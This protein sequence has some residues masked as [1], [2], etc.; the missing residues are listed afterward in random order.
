M[1]TPK[2]SII[3]PVY[4]LEDYIENCVRSLS[5]QV[6]Q[7]IEIII[8]DDGSS[9]NSLSIIK[10]LAATDSRIIYKTQPNGGAAKARNTG[11]DLSTGDYIAF[12]DGDDMLSTNAISDNIGYFVD[13]EIDWVAFSIRRV[14]ADGEYI[15]AKGIYLDFII[16]SFE[17]ISSESF[18]PYFYSHKLSGVACA[19]IYR[20]SSIK[21][22]SFVDGKYYEDGIYFIDLLCSTQ[23][24][25]LSPRGE[26]LY[27]DR[28]GSSQKAAL[29]YKHLESDYFCFTRR[30]SKYRLLF[31]QYE[32]YYS[33][34]ENIYY[35]YLKNEVAKRT[36][37]AKF[38]FNKYKNFMISP[39]KI[40]IFKELKFI[41]YTVVGYKRL[42]K[43]AES[44]I[45][46]PKMN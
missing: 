24:S 44:L 10:H 21:A 8:V 6:Y 20:K 7:N 43:I 12:V 41:L 36:E 4:N 26:Y 33:K 9:D 14:N 18:V 23:Y 22:I 5:A 30:M 19:A 2:V 37:G 29:D 27:V 13:D 32:E 42:K 45:S 28:N 39:L 17:K 11:L 1:F 38:F 46:E 16:S 3:V 34:Q 25:I 35:Y 31:P 40:N 15:Q